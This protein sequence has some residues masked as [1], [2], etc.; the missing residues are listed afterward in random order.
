MNH[1]FQI[2]KLTIPNHQTTLRKYQTDA[3]KN[4]EILRKAINNS[5]KITN[6]IQK[7]VSDGITYH[8]PGAIAN[9]F[10]SFFASV[11][12]NIVNSIN[13]P[14]PPLYEQTTTNH[15]HIFKFSDTPVMEVEVREAVAQINGK[16]SLDHNKISSSFIKKNYY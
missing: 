15:V 11:A 2:S 9:N 1:L 7:I 13:P 8:D 4:W 5:S 10:N 16:K 3:K 14:S 6:S 12:K